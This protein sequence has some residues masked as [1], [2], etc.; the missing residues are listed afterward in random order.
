MMHVQQYIIKNFVPDIDTEAGDFD[1]YNFN[2]QMTSDRVSP[3]APPLL[4]SP[5]EQAMERV[6]EMR[7]EL[8]GNSL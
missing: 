2:A 8:D 5:T 3:S 1:A 4:P 7:R 6:A